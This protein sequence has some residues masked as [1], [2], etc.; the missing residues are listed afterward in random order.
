MAQAVI[1]EWGQFADYLAAQPLCVWAR[2]K[3]Q[4]IDAGL[5]RETG[6]GPIHATAKVPH[7]APKNDNAELAAAL[8]SMA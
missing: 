6:G 4:K 3:Q 1:E 7:D 5:I 8:A 2:Q